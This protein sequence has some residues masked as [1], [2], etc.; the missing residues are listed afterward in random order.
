M[1]FQYLLDA[2]IFI[3]AK[4]FHY[5]FE[6]FYGF[7]EWLDK[8]NEKGVIGSVRLIGKEVM[9]GDDELARWASDR[10]SNGWFL[11]EDDELTQVKFSKIAE[12]VYSQ[13]FKAH[14][15]EEF[16]G[17]ADPWLIAKASVIGATVVTYEKFVANSK[18]KIFIPNVCNAFHVPYMDIY[19]L[20]H[21]T[22]ARFG[23]Q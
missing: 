22:G 16:L 4:N 17:G 2:N 5:R 7:W 6:T 11:L 18:K 13:P 3:Q 19:D 8:E 14:A 9:N 21:K 10:S 12:W 20:I 23:L 1:S 15:K